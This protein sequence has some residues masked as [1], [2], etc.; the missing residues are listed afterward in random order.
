MMYGVGEAW[1][2]TRVGGEVTEAGGPATGVY[3]EVTGAAGAGA[4]SLGEDVPLA[5]TGVLARP[6]LEPPP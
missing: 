6:V 3:G 2:V 5:V 4:V 1:E